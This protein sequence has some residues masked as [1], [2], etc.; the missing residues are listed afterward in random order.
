LSERIQLSRDLELEVLFED[1]WLL[2]INKPAGL[3][4]APEKWQPA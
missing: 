1:R 4:V 3:I 2:A